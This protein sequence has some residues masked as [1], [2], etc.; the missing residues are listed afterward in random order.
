MR[1]TVARGLLLVSLRT[2]PRRGSL[3]LPRQVAPGAVLQLVLAS[4]DGLFDAW[5]AGA[6]VSGPYV[7]VA[8]DRST[9]AGRRVIRFGRAPVPA[10]F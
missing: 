1:M 8:G 9:V 5:I 7:E 2:V 4:G 6:G 3:G 10:V